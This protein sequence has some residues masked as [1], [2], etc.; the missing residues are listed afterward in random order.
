[1]KI[2]IL[3]GKAASRIN[4]TPLVKTALIHLVHVPV[5]D[6]VFLFVILGFTPG[7]LSVANQWNELL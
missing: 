6:A 7:D 2:L 3:R 1:M 4:M 5:T